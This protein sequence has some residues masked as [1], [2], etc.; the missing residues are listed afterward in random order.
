MVLLSAQSAL[1]ILA[2]AANPGDYFRITVVD[3]QTGRGV[4]LVE[5]RTVNEVRYVTDSNGVVA[6]HEPGLMDQSVFFHVSSHG[7]EFAADGFGFRGKSLVT[8]P[9]GSAELKIK[10]LN[11]AERLYRVTGG[12]IY[13]DSALLGLPVP[14]RQGLLNA[15]V[16]GSDSVVNAIYRGRLY[17]FWGDTH[18]PAY[19]LGNFHVPGATSLLPNAGGLPPAV[20]VELEYFVDDKGFAKP[21][22]QMPGQGPTWI[23]GLVVLADTRGQERMYASYVKVKPPMTIYRRGLAAWNDEQQQFESLAEFD[24][25]TSAAPDGGHPFLHT[26]GGEKYVYFATPYPLRRVLADPDKLAQPATY[27]SFTPLQEGSTL[28]EPKIDRDDAGRA[29]Y[30]WRKNTPYLDPLQQAAFVRK[31]LLTENECLLQ[32]RDAAS[33]KGVQAAR[34][35]VY[36]ND[37]RRRWIM[38]ALESFGTSMLG[39]IWYAEADSPLGPWVYARKIVTHQR[40]SFYNPKQ[41]PMFDE[42]GG[43]VIYFEGTYTAT[44]SGNTHGTPWYDYNQMMYRL[45]LADRRLALPAPVYESPGD[46]RPRF[47]MGRQNMPQPRGRIA[48]FALDRPID[49]AVAVLADEPDERPLKLHI[50]TA[51]P[52]ARLEEAGGS[53]R[54]PLFFA[55]PAEMP[56]PPATTLPLFEYTHSDGVQRAYSTAQSLPNFRRGEKPLC[57]VW[58]SPWSEGFPD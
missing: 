2:L 10:R 47:S 13:R 37:Y 22:C 6:F 34:G 28:A 1:L 25:D 52:K 23:G 29:R 32:L 7:Y 5:L 41:H 51:G 11:I 17:W 18:R 36:W 20:G 58:A 44:F 24:A 26:D 8:R 31:G 53:G 19:P 33:G 3:E 38:I 27:E 56:D 57:L 48:F 40:Y 12:G 9:G 4:P 21:T 50:E 42:Q 49:G 45:D 14:I 39:E 35:T 55:L 15:Q 16:F 46:G 30:R 54:T 43:R